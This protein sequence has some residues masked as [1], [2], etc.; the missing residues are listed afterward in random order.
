MNPNTAT[1]AVNKNDKN[2]TI[3]NNNDQHL[4]LQANAINPIPA[5]IITYIIAPS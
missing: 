3:T 1:A 5:T 2:S 4:S